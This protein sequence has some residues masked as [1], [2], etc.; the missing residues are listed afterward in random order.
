MTKGRTES[1]RKSGSITVFGMRNAEMDFMYAKYTYLQ[2]LHHRFSFD[3][4]FS[5]YTK[6]TILVYRDAGLDCVTVF[7]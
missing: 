7:R 1:E 5:I 4:V 2:Y 6:I 3:L